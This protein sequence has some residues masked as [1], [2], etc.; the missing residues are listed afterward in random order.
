MKIIFAV[1]CCFASVLT[2]QEPSVPVSMPSRDAEYVAA[3]AAPG[4]RNH[5]EEVELH[6][7]VESRLQQLEKMIPDV[8]RATKEQ[9]WMLS[10]WEDAYCFAPGREKV[11][12]EEILA[13]TDAGRG[14]NEFAPDYRYDLA[15]RWCLGK[16]REWEE[17]LLEHRFRSSVQGQWIEEAMGAYRFRMLYDLWKKTKNAATAERIYQAF[18][19][20]FPDVMKEGVSREEQMSAAIQWYEGFLGFSSFKKD[21]DYSP[22]NGVRTG[23]AVPFFQWKANW[24]SLED[25]YGW[26]IVMSPDGEYAVMYYCN[27]TGAITWELYVF[28]RTAPDRYENVALYWVC[29]RYA[30][31]VGIDDEDIE[32]SLVFTPEGLEFLLKDEAGVHRHLFP[33]SSESGSWRY[34]ADKEQ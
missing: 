4:P 34:R 21:W 3:T 18:S 33:Y 23:K 26:P 11:W 10:A 30:H 22:V 14:R 9:L 5:G 32:K 6:A 1:C 7:L 25:E 24:E 13:D 29:S 2:G 16:G 12:F 15:L 19:R 17:R 27:F 31:I 8:R 28:R 20:A